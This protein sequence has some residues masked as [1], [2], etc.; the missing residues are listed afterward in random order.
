MRDLSIRKEVEAMRRLNQK[1]EKRPEKMEGATLLEVLVSIL[2]FSCGML[3]IVGLQAS[4]FQNSGDV[5]YRAEAIH[6]VNAYVGKMKAMTPRA[7]AGGAGGIE[8]DFHSGN[9]FDHFKAEVAAKL[10]EG[11][12]PEV[13]FYTGADI[14]V[15]LP[16]E[17]RL[18]DITVTWQ[19]PGEDDVR[20]YMQTSVI[21]NN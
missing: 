19:R 12:V 15:A 14:G 21:G 9:E 3:A 20:Q 8:G 17:T 10:P 13:R 11:D 18:V 16:P 6:M 4:S 7:N 1:S 2:I 5:Q